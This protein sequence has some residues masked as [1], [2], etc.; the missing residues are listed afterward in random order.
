MAESKALGLGFSAE[1]TDLF[2]A[3]FGEYFVLEK[4]V[5]SPAVDVGQ[6]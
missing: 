6:S 5:C 2:V 3:A 1:P 4:F